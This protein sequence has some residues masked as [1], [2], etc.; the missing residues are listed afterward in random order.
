[1]G[2]VITVAQGKGGSGKTTTSINLACAIKEKG[3]SVII[4]DMD[5]DKPDAVN[6]ANVGDNQ[7]ILKDMVVEVFDDNPMDKID[8]LKN[9]YEYV[10]LDTPPNFQ[11]ASIKAVMLSDFVILPTSDSMLDQIA[12]SN[13][14]SIPKMA[15]KPFS[16]LA[17][18]IDR[19][20]NASQALL[21][22]IKKTNNSFNTFI[23]ARK[24]MVES[25]FEGKWIG[26]YEKYGDNHQQYIDLADELIEKLKGEYK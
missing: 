7:N 14:I 20:T 8:E 11:T 3:Y 5:R 21:D 19:R 12:L 26:E 13:A 1:M 16:L 24:K 18:R 15:K 17:N 4:A 23:T 9:N 6:W 10:F 22:N 25:Q 2:Y